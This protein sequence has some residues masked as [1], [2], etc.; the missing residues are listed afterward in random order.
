MTRLL[1]LSLAPILAVAE[2]CAIAAF[3]D[4]GPLDWQFWAIVVPIAF[5]LAY[6]DARMRA[7]YPKR[8]ETQR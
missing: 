5:P 2:G 6:L 1:A 3:T 8:K 4:I 7:R